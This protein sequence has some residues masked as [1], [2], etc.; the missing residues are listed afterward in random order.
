MSTATPPPVTDHRVPGPSA[1]GSSAAI[2]FLTTFGAT[3]L[4]LVA[5]VVAVVALELAWSSSATDTWPAAGAVGTGWAL[6]AAGWL[7]S[8]VWAPDAVLAVLAAPAAVL[9]GP[10]ALGWLTPAGLVLWGPVGTVLAAATAMAVHPPAR[11]A[12]TSA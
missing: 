2:R 5:A 3:L 12:P 10:A 6:A 7:R 11:H 9:A 4:P 1:S 8:R